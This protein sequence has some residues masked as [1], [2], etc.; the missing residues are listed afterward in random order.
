MTYSILAA[1]FICVLPLRLHAGKALP[2]AER[3]AHE[4]AEEFREARHERFKTLERLRKD[5]RYISEEIDREIVLDRKKSLS[6]YSRGLLA[7]IAR[8]RSSGNIHPELGPTLDRIEGLSR[9]FPSRRYAEPY[10]RGLVKAL[11]HE[12]RW[13]A[14]TAKS[15]SELLSLLNEHLKLPDSVDAAGW[16]KKDV[17][18]DEF[19][20][21]GP[22]KIFLA[23]HRLKRP[24][25]Y[26]AT[27]A[28]AV[29]G[30]RHNVQIGVDVTGMVVRHKRSVDGD[31][32]FDIGNLHIELTPEWRAAHRRIPK[33][34]AGQ[35]VRARGW[36]YWDMFH[37]AEEEY[38]P[39]DPV[40]GVNRVTMWEIHPVLDIQILP[41]EP[42]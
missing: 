19:V 10:A 22:I 39:D 35:R 27:T 3:K 29:V 25:R 15:E 13:I 7:R 6:A 23:K 17:P 33:P 28:A 32:T 2:E 4:A 37:K 16:L 42:E 41:A 14:E 34:V 40:L 18:K 9:D 20:A 31:Y 12:L 24:P 36:T 38:D 11:A 26:A 8:L 5:L 30:D 21:Q 1:V